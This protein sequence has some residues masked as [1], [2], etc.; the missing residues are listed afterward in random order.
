MKNKIE[1]DAINM[2]DNVLFA[3]METAREELTEL[4]GRKIESR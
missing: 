4:V 2:A 3:A 1:E